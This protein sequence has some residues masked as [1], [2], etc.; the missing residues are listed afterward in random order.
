[1]GWVSKACI[2][3]RLEKNKPEKADHST[4]VTERRKSQQLGLKSKW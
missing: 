3:A 1:L 2:E 4:K